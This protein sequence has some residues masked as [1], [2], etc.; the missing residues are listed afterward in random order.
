MQRGLFLS[1]PQPTIRK[2]NA[3]VPSHA[4]GPPGP[5]GIRLRPHPGPG[6][7][8]GAGG[9]GGYAGGRVYFHCAKQ[10][11][12]LD[13]VR[14][15]PKASLCVVEKDAVVPEKYTTAYRSVIV[16]GTVRVLED[17][18]AMH[19]ALAAL[20]RKY[21]PAESEASHRAEIARYWDEVCVLELTP[22]HISGKQ[23][24]ELLHD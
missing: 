20:A 8:G 1:D 14:R 24:L 13:A 11:H 9:A 17:P 3:Y 23:G 19:A 4:P 7:L 15:C 6:H 2:E 16:F 12:K 22:A 18:A 10:G 5:A 21:A